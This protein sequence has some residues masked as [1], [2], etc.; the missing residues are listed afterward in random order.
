[1]SNWIIFYSLRSPIPLLIP[2]GQLNSLFINKIRTRCLLIRLR[3]CSLLN[4]LINCKIIKM[5]KFSNI[6]KSK[7]QIKLQLVQHRL[8]PLLFLTGLL[9]SNRMKVNYNYK[10]FIFIRRRIRFNKGHR[11]E[12]WSKTRP[13]VTFSTVD[14]NHLNNKD[15]LHRNEFFPSQMLHLW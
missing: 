2:Q 7:V 13:W 5:C 12:V 4:W 15:T 9:S 3:I 6:C 14:H 10:L 8:I 1:M 11:Q